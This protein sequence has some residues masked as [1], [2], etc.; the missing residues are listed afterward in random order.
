MRA[1]IV[2]E[3]T[4]GGVSPSTRLLLSSRFGVVMPTSRV[5][6]PATGTNWEGGLKPDLVTTEAQA[7]D[8]AHLA[9]LEDVVAQHRDDPLTVE[10]E[11]AIAGL[12]RE[13]STAV[14][15]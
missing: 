12:K 8:V 2:G 4:R 1:K 9:A 15:H 6:N 11:K 7:L 10:I 13:A 14:K 5:T 3:R